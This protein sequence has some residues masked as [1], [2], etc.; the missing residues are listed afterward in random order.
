MKVF[1]LDS[2]LYPDVVIDIFPKEPFLFEAEYAAAVWKEIAPQ[3]R[4]P[5]VSIPTLIRMKQDVDREKDRTDIR[6]LRKF[7]PSHES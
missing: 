5:V 2:D 4:I 1:N 7:I 3:L 6:E